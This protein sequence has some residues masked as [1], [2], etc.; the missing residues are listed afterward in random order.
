MCRGQPTLVI[1][2]VTLTPQCPAVALYVQ[3]II[4]TS[5]G[6]YIKGVY[7]TDS[8]CTSKVDCAIEKRTHN[9]VILPPDPLTVRISVNRTDPP[10][11]TPENPTDYRAAS[12]PQNVTCTVTGGT[13]DGPTY[14][15][16]STC[17]RCAFSD[18]TDAVIT[19]A[20][21][22]SGDIG[23]HT[24]TATRGGVTAMD[25]IVFNIVGEWQK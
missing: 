18:R 12:G 14:R 7:M 8:R 25:S 9:C 5:I 11:F 19:R 10:G 16:S 6:V 22:H 3:C 2:L 20:A 13:G 17:N 23:T 15:W 1:A 21:L 4:C 24:C